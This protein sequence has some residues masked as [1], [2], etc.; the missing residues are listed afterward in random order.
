[1]IDADD[2]RAER[3]A[4]WIR[5]LPLADRAHLTGTTVVLERIRQRRGASLPHPYDEATLREA[6]L[7]RAAAAEARRIATLYA[8]APPHL[9][10]DGIDDHQRIANFCQS[11]AD[12]VEARIPGAAGPRSE[13]TA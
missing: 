1:M 13:G 3:L 9:G 7:P 8:V 2:G 12:T 5:Q 4:Q 10:P 11:L 6:P